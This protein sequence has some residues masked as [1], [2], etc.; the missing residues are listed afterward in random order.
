MS[1]LLFSLGNSTLSDGVSRIL[2]VPLSKIMKFTFP[3]GEILLRAD[4]SVRGKDIFIINSNPFPVNENI[5]SLLIFID[6]LK[7][8]SAESINVFMP[9]YLYARQDR[10]S[11]PREPISASLLANLL[12]TA[13]ATRVITTDLHSQQV[14]GFFSCLE[15]DLTAIP[16][17][18][19]TLRKQLD[20]KKT[21]IVS[22]DHGGVTRARRVA[23]ALDLPLVI[24][25][26]R[27]DEE[28]NAEVC[29]II[30]NV[31]NKNAVLVD[32]IIDT[33]GSIIEGAKALKSNGALKV[34]A[35][36]THGVFSDPAFD[37]L[38]KNNIFEKIYVTDSIPLEEKFIKSNVNIEILSLAPLIANAINSIDNRTPL[39]EIY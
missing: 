20:L 1:Y 21:V 9:Y 35:C 3:S 29:H 27:R 11:K 22:P 39:S 8:A 13:G 5:M 25:D 19:D 4:E 10:K 24:I 28:Y 7:R 6:S 23:K 16:L 31:K 15:D 18:S 33:A 14:Q 38:S 37:R 34:Y 30:G 12:V 17:I 36:A 32:D 2:N 26:K